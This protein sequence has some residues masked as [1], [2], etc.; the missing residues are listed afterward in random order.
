MIRSTFQPDACSTT[1]NIDRRRRASRA[2]S[3]QYSSGESERDE[4]LAY[5]DH[6]SP[7]PAIRR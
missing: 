7:P 3:A 6:C 2:A 5:L 1:L 4:L